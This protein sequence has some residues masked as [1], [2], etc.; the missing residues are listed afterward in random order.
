[1]KIYDK[2]GLMELLNVKSNTAF[3][4]MR[5][6]GFRTGYSPRSPLRI[7]EEGVREWVEH[8]QKMNIDTAKTPLN[9]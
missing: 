4:I 7:T 3:R 2:Q 8:Q 6:Y 1:M 9:G 5:E